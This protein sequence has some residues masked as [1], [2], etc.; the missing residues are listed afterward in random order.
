MFESSLSCPALQCWRL[1]VVEVSFGML[2]GAVRSRLKTWLWVVSA[3]PSR[4]AQSLR[5]SVLFGLYLWQPSSSQRRCLSRVFHKKHSSIGHRQE[6]SRMPS[7]FLTDLALAKHSSAIAELTQA[8]TR[9]QQGSPLLS[10]RSLTSMFSKT[11]LM[12]WLKQNRH[13][14]KG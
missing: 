5:R 1:D 14:H 4:I 2:T 12:K 11:L 6:R 3:P 10:Q 7:T 13:Q 8:V 9:S